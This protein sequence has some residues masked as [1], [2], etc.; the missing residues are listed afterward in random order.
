MSEL[1]KSKKRSKLLNEPEE[2][3]VPKKRRFNKSFKNNY[4]IFQLSQKRKTNLKI[5][6]E[7]QLKKL[8]RMTIKVTMK[9]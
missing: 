3:V 4:L 9:L 6:M 7:K 2:I 8:K 1:K 5:K